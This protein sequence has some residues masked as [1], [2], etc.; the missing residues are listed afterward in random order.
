MKFPI[1]LLATFVALLLPFSSSANDPTERSI[2]TA[3]CA[4]NLSV[5]LSATQIEVEGDLTAVFLLTSEMVDAGSASDC[6]DISI[7]TLLECVAGM[8]VECLA[9][10]AFDFA[11]DEE[12]SSPLVTVELDIFY[13]ADNGFSTSRNAMVTNDERDYVATMV[14]VP[15]GTHAIRVVATGDCGNTTEEVVEFCVTGDRLVEPNCIPALTITGIPGLPFASAWVSDFIAA[16]IFDCQGNVISSYSLYREE[17]T[18]QPDFIPVEERLELMLGCEDQVTSIPARIYAFAEDGSFSSCTVI[19][20]TSFFDGCQPTKNISGTIFFR[21]DEPLEGVVVRISGSSSGTTLTNASGVY[22]FSGLP[23][24]GDFVI[25]PEWNILVN[26]EQVTVSDVVLIGNVI[27][28]T[29]T[30]ENGYDYLAADVDQDQALT[31]GDMVSIQRVILGLDDTFSTGKSWGFINADV[32]IGNPFQELFSTTIT[33]NDLHQNIFD[34]D[35][36]GFAY[37]D[38][39]SG[40]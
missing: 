34:A 32:G 13:D 21:E 29:T 17:E 40:N 28:G 16:D 2:P 19:I 15:V 9:E 25:A 31:V 39:N 7:D 35:F 30:L 22:S 11:I 12:C 1:T 24:G 26:L 5:P 33:I 8:D 4:T 14:D 20:N 37:G 36:I 10:V 27:L 38:V 18:I 23:G 3:N 6:C